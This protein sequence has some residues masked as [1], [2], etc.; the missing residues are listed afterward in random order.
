M[1]NVFIGDLYVA[2][3]VGAAVRQRPAERIA[4]RSV[5]G[6]VAGADLAFARRPETSAEPLLQLLGEVARRLLQLVERLGLR[7][8]RVPWLAALQRAGG[9]AHGPLGAAERVRYVAHPVAELPHHAPV[10]VVLGGGVV[11]L[12]GGVVVFGGGVVVTVPVHVTPLSVNEDG[13]G[14]L[15]VH[16][17]WKPMVVEAPVPRWPFQD[18]FFAV[19]AEPLW[20]Y[21]ADQPWV[22]FCPESGKVQPSVQASTSEPR[23]VT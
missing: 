6:P 13:V 16:V 4:F 2:L 14:L 7:A 19:T 21:V 10:R 18:A 22:T 5:G 9:I 1:Q 20:L 11:V 15:P 3:V 12:G 17:P 8:D 23:F